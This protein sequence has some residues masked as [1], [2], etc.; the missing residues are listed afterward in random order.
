LLAELCGYVPMVAVVHG[1]SAGH[2]ALCAPLCD[3][4]I[5]VE[6]QGQLFTAG[7]PLVVAATGEQVDKETLGG[8]HVQ[9]TS[10]VAHV[11]APD[12]RSA[13]ALARRYLSYLPLNAWDYPPIHDSHDGPRRVDELID[14]I[15]AGARQGYDIG[16]VIETV[17]DVD[18]VLEL[19]SEYGTSIVTAMARLGGWPVGVVANQPAVRAGSIDAEG[20]EKAARFVDLM[21]AFH[22]PVIWLADNPG[23]LPG[24]AAER[25]GALRSAARM[26]V[27]MH[28]HPG[29]KMHVTLRKAYGFGSS[30]MA[31]NPF[32]GQTFSVA[33]PDASVGAMPAK[34]GSDA[35]KVDDATRDELTA[36]EFGGPWRMADSLSYDDVLHPGELRNALLDA[37]RLS[38]GRR[39]ISPE[40]TRRPSLH[41]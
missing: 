20:A 30:V 31:Q 41:P 29:P 14:L 28:R 26:F 4:I 13:L 12:D 8:A 40:P 38:Q 1:A 7:P 9:L 34:G 15:P 10:G 17:F 27:A 23:V 5:M 25:A 22:L 11:A 39:T 19:Q 6:G 3:V 16:P 18:S 36:A 2:G 21:G 24:T 32:S 33:F 37:L 35:A